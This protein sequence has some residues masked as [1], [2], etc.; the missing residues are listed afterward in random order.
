MPWDGPDLLIELRVQPRAAR[1]EL[2]PAQPRPRL[3]LRAPAVD[4]RANDAAIAWL[5]EACG[6]ARS[7]VALVR[8]HRSRDK[9]FR[10]RA[11]VRLPAALAGP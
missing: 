11:P 10:I 8:G 7:H 9:L 2:V 4:G 3:R 5:A 6:V 1:D